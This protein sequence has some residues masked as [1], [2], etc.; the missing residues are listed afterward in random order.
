MAGARSA[1]L[2]STGRCRRPRLHFAPDAHLSRIH[3]TLLLFLERSAETWSR[4]EVVA[5]AARSAAGIVPVVLVYLLV[6]RVPWPRAFRVRFLAVHMLAAPTLAAVWVL[7]SWAIGALVGGTTSARALER[8]G[9]EALAVGIYLYVI[10]A[11]VAYAVESGARAARAEAVAA[12]TQLAALRAQVHP[13]FLFNALHT[14]MYLVQTDPGRAAHALELLSGLLRTTL[15]DQRHEV[16]LEDEW[17]FVSRYLEL[18]R[19]R[20]GDRLV[21]RAEIAPHLLA[22]RVPTF[23]LQTLVENAV[24]HGAA[25]RRAPTEIVVTATN[26][27]GD[28]RLSVRNSGDARAPRP[29][30]SVA[31]AGTG[32]ARLRQRLTGLYGDAAR[33]DCRAAV[34]GGFDA[35][36][37]VPCDRGSGS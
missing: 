13:H 8:E 10:I 14:V 2:S 29:A 36:L 5:A 17:R 7:V 30:S 15:E 9:S 26:G 21:V 35:V 16:S 4:D 32:L 34:E 12:Q 37:V 22:A 25:P 31:G 3:L 11:G 27:G 33:L 24:Q 28:L 18:E 6:R 20:F 23:A 1:G 19:L